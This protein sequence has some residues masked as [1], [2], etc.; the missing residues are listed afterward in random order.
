MT[1]PGAFC[2]ESGSST[3]VKLDGWPSPTYLVRG[4]NDRGVLMRSLGACLC[5]RNHRSLSKCHLVERFQHATEWHTPLR[6]RTNPVYEIKERCRSRNSAH[7]D[8]QHHQIRQTGPLPEFVDKQH[9]TP[10]FFGKALRL[11]PKIRRNCK[12]VRTAVL[13]NQS[14]TT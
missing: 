14:K 6:A 11:T 9:A 12:D 7:V 2:A 1:K 5:I 3:A 8:P 4:S 13:R 10:Q